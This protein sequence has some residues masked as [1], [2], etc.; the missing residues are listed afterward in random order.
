MS[1]IARVIEEHCHAIA[2]ELVSTSRREMPGAQGLSHDELLDSLLEFLKAMA[3]DVRRGEPTPH[4]SE[5]AREHG[6]QRWWVGYDLRSLILEYGVLRR[7]ILRRVLSSGHTPAVEDVDALTQALMLSVAD[8]V[9]RYVE[10]SEASL[11]EALERAR[12]ATKAREEVLAIISHDLKNPLQV[13]LSGVHL[14]LYQVAST[15]P[16]NLAVIQRR[17]EAMQRASA[18]MDRLITDILDLARINAGETKLAYT[19]ATS[20]ELLRN[21]ADAVTPAAEQRSVHLRLEASLDCRL[22][23]DRDRVLQVLEN[24][25]SNAIK[26]TPVG[27][28]VEIRV[29]DTS[30]DCRFEVSDEGPGIS[31]ENLEHL[32]EPYWQAPNTAEQGTG[33]GLSI[34][35]AL[36]ELHG[37]VISAKSQVGEGS[38]FTVQIPKRPPG[39][40]AALDHP[41]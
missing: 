30:T 28:T 6:E 13:I 25:V 39:V 10:T 38:T 9:G 16:P 3:A 15:S 20:G 36:V 23:C 35:R 37:G 4:A 21:L 26:F 7:I 22:L 1:S 34:A 5:Y 17:L 12:Q 24:L 19:E 14:L 40:D 11:N 31:P 41:R 33:L 29:A 32:F 18:R 27:S 2:E 8:A